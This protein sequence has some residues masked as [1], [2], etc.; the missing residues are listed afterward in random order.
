MTLLEKSGPAATMG[1]S[2]GSMRRGTL[3]GPSTEDDTGSGVVKGGGQNE[4]QKLL[5][6]LVDST[7]SITVDGSQFLAE[8]GGVGPTGEAP[9]EFESMM[10]TLESAT[11]MSTTSTM[12]VDEEKH[13][14]V[15]GCALR[16]GV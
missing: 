4:Q 16:A 11:L 15:G 6:W 13:K 12:L 14:Q 3:S 5:Q 7:A 10:K 8:L 9:S 2:G 1:P